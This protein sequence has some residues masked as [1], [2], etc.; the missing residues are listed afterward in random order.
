MKELLVEALEAL[1]D[2]ITCIKDMEA[3]PGVKYHYLEELK[4]KVKKI[5]D[6]ID[7]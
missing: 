1:D 4:R 6:K 7:W 5:E 2:A 3:N